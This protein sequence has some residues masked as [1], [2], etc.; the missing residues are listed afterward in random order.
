MMEPSSGAL[1]KDHQFGDCEQTGFG[2]MHTFPTVDSSGDSRFTSDNVIGK[3]EKTDEI[4]A[5]LI[6]EVIV[7]ARLEL[8]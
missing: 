2:Q 6:A 8:R 3:W 7:T 4:P 5:A 1:S